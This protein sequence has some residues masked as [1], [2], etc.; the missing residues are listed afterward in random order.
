MP[1][2]SSSKPGG[3][4]RRRPAVELSS[5]LPKSTELK[6][7]RLVAQ[8]SR[9]ALRRRW[10]PIKIGGFL[11]AGCCFP[12]KPQAI[13][14]CGFVLSDIEH[15]KIKQPR[16]RIRSQSDLNTASRTGPGS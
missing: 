13:I 6:D 7:R 1:C 4:I 9:P 2:R 8:P 3:T 5:L 10:R 14:A 11:E 12:E 15:N 16:Q